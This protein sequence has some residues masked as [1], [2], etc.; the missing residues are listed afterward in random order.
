MRVPS[1]SITPALVDRLRGLPEAKD[2]TMLFMEGADEP[3]DLLPH[4]ARKRHFL[5]RDDGHRKAARTQRRR[6]LQPDK[7]RAHDD[8]MPGGLCPFDD[9]AA[10]AKGAQIEHMR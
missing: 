10:V 2:H 8:G 5:G 9:G 1:F 3:A 4:D 6:H 7:A